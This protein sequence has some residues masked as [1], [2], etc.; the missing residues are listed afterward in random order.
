MASLSYK[1]HPFLEETTLVW[2]FFNGNLPRAPY[3]QQFPIFVGV[4]KTCLRGPADY[5]SI[6][7][8]KILVI[9]LARPG[10]LPPCAS[11]TELHFAKGFDF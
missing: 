2:L 8:E 6:L 7:L 9:I 1:G 10:K 5:S 11:L 3:N 4:L